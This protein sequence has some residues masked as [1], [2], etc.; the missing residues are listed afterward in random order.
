MSH[1]P[2]LPRFV[3]LQIARLTGAMIALA[4]AVI[5]SHGQPALA[6]VP[7]VLGDVLIVGGAIAFFLIPYAL[8]KYWKRKS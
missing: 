2:A 7:D 1:D 8:A 4:G 5:L 6:Q 3:L